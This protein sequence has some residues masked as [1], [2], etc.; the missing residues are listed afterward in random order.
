MLPSPLA[1][2][3]RIRRDLRGRLN[4]RAWRAALAAWRAE[5]PAGDYAQLYAWY[6]RERPRSGRHLPQTLGSDINQRFQRGRALA[7]RA[8]LVEI[9]LRP[10]HAVLDHG[11]GSLWVGG[12]VWP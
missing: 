11:C 4:N 1:F 3:A 8:L 2:A 9:G 6:A 10:E 5:H 12:R 7:M